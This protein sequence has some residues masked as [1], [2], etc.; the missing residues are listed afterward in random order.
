MNC[1]ESYKILLFAIV[2]CTIYIMNVI[3]E[4]KIKIL[5]RNIVEKFIET[6]QLFNMTETGIV[7]QEIKIQQLAF[8]IHSWHETLVACSRT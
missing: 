8:I 2:L 7:P 4:V 5:F 1:T 6:I 3:I